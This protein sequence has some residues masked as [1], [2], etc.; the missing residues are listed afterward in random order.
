[1]G[2]GNDQRKHIDSGTARHSPNTPHT[3]R[4]E[5]DTT[6]ITTAVAQFG[7][8]DGV[9]GEDWFG[10]TEWEFCWESNSGIVTG[11]SEY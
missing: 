4:T 9:K 10:D 6:C 5:D 1:M 3:P 11:V 8:R 7:G 2:L